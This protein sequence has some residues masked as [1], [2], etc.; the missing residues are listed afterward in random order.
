VTE[1][2]EVLDLVDKYRM[3]DIMSSSM[4]GISKFYLSFMPLSFMRTARRL[5]I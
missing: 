4:T 5:S 2:G 3:R 1:K